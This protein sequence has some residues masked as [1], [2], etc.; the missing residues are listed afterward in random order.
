MPTTP[1]YKDFDDLVL[2]TLEDLGRDDLKNLALS[3]QNY[4][5][6][7]II[8][9]KGRVKQ[10]TGT[11]IRKNV[12]YKLPGTVKH[13]GFEQPNKV[14]IPQ[15]TA[16]FSVDWCHI[17]QTWG[18]FKQEMMMNGG[19]A[20]I[21]NIIKPRRQTAKDE[22]VQEIEEKFWALPDA[23]DPD[24]PKGIFYALPFSATAGFNGTYA[25]GF[26]DKYGESVTK[27]PRLKCY[28]NAYKDLTKADGIYK[29]RQAFQRTNWRPPLD[30]T[31]M[32][33]D[34]GTKYRIFT[35][36][37][38]EL[39]FGNLAEGQNDK[40]GSDVASMDGQVV[41]KRVPIIG[42]SYLSEENNPDWGTHPNPI[43]GVD[44]DT[45]Q[46]YAL[47]GDHMVEEG[48]KDIPD[49][50]NGRG[51]QLSSTYQYLNEDPSRSF[52]MYKN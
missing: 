36:F 48:P 32:R 42:V 40:L 11:G 47:K 34:L 6:F 33:S 50:M 52:T 37:D 19:A 44:M 28:T 29:I 1:A 8:W 23:N 25:T 21:N 4:P 24:V 45:F 17:E 14:T 39:K 46:L 22:F 27:I 41:I 5:A 20:R 43:M 26:T 15:V 18:W 3:Y 2:Q 7:S 9:K 16:K 30:A 51:F 35:D 10:I 12:I 13:Q 49:Y 31:Q 38:S